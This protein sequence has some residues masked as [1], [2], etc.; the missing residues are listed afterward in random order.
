MKQWFFARRF[1]RFD[2]IAMVAYTIALIKIDF[3]FNLD[4]LM[5]VAA[6][7]VACEFSVK[8]ED[9]VHEETVSKKAR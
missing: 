4:T 2:L 7:V 3:G 8:M 1:N 5:L 9:E 6:F